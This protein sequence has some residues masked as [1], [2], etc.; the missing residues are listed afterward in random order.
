MATV[1]PLVANAA[2]SLARLPSAKSGDIAR[3]SPEGFRPAYWDDL[4]VFRE[5]A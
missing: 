5:C 2:T 4:K 3:L 1:F